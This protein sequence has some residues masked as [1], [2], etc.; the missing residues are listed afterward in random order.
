MS[1]AEVYQN[2]LLHGRGRRFLHPRGRWEEERAAA[3]RIAYRCHM[4]PAR[5]DRAFWLGVARGFGEGRLFSTGAKPLLRPRH[6][7]PMIPEEL[8]L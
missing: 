1:V 3:A 6:W 5:E 4:L 7:S 2:G 8:P